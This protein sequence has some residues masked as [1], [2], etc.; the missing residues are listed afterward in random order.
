MTKLSGIVEYA[1]T[2]Y[3]V[4]ALAGTPVKTIDAELRAHHQYFPFDPLFIDQEATIG[5]T[6]AAGVAGPCRLRHG[7]IRDFVIGVQFIDGTGK[8]IRGG[9]KVVKNA[10]GFDFPKMM[11]GSCG[12]LG[13]LT[14]ITLKV[15]PRPAQYQTLRFSFPQLAPAIDFQTRLTRSS[16]ELEAIDLEP[17]ADVLVRVAGLPEATDALARR[18]N[19]LAD[20]LPASHSPSDPGADEAELWRPL[21]NGT[22]AAAEECLVRA[23]LTPR[24]LGNV[25][26]ALQRLQVK[27]RFSVAGNVVWIAWPE[28]R[29]LDE[30]DEALR[31]LQRSATVLTG[32]AQRTHLGDQP[33]QS[34]QVRIQDA[35][36][37]LQRF[38]RECFVTS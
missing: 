34:F 17:S 5:G 30:L 19:E 31:A 10:A 37:P 22:F 26:T 16:L 2:E 29:G 12:R 13:V 6:I 7:G 33:G 11:V 9:G 35:L 36:D 20:V 14:E 23:T 25:A 28:Q 24:Q 32:N 1:P 21:Q 18:V 38:P 8:L 27:H 3:V 15:L 4:T